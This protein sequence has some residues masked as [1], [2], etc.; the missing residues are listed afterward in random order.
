MRFLDDPPRPLFQRLFYNFWQLVFRMLVM[1]A[2]RV[3][4]FG[5][6]NYPREGGVLICSNHQSNL[7]PIIIGCLTPRRINYLGKK[8]LFRF[9]P[10]GWALHLVDTI[11]ID[12]ESTGVSGMKETLRRLKRDESVLL[13]PEG[14][15]TFDGEMTPL[16]SGFVALA[17]RVHSPL[18]PVAIEGPFDAW[19]R[20]RRFPRLG[21]AVV[22]IGKPIPPAEFEGLSDAEI[23]ALVDNR[24]KDCFSTARRHYRRATG[25]DRPQCI[26]PPVAT[27]PEAPPLLR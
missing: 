15:R 9:P 13:F 17:K 6:D 2:Y 14:Q 27:R 26:A 22:V 12:R 7:D 11:P 23:V 10:L 5:L 25:T 16:M 3:R 20:T 4:C 21:R 18:L 8:S 24:I 1:V 19:P